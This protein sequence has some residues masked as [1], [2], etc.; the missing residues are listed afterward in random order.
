MKE[1]S[2]NIVFQK[3]AS[4]VI[5]VIMEEVS[6]EEMQSTIKEKMISPMLRVVFKEVHQYVYGLFILISVT[7]LFSLLSFGV[8]LTIY[9]LR[10]RT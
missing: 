10:I 6:K 1:C 9:T 2:E 5:N 7:L 3:F 8:L 4:K